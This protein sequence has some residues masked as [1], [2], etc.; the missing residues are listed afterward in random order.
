M[1]KIKKYLPKFRPNWRGALP[2]VL[3]FGAAFLIV[4]VFFGLQFVMTASVITVLF[5]IRHARYNSWGYLFRQLV[6]CEALALFAMIATLD[7]PPFSALEFHH[8]LCIGFPAIFTIRAKRIFCQRHDICIPAIHAAGTKGLWRTAGS[9]AGL[10]G[11]PCHCTEAV[12]LF[13]AGQKA[14]KTYGS[15]VAHRSETAF[16]NAHPHC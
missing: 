5:Q 9:G 6:I 3:F 13:A 2:V 16:S 12:P 14:G 4:A 7:T 11:I 10:L 1:E 8:S 15:D